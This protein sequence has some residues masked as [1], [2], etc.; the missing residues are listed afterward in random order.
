[1]KI[2]PEP[3]KKDEKGILTWSLTLAPQEKKEIL[4]DFT[5]EYPKD[6]NIIG[7]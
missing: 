6:A 3:P 5:V 1:M 7:L 2:L 4:I